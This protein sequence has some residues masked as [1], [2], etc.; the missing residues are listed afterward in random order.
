MQNSSVRT[1]NIVA[2]LLGV[3]LLGGL[4]LTSLYN[5]LLFHSLVE[6]FTIVVA[7]GIFMIAWNARAYLNNNYLLFLGIAAVFIAFL[8]IFHTLAYKG[9]GVF[10]DPS[11]NTATQV[12][13]GMQY[14][15]G[16]SLLVAPIFIGR[17]LRV[18]LQ[19]AAYLLVTAL[20]L[21]AI[22]AWRIFPVAYVQVLGLTPFKIASEYITVAFFL[23]SIAILLWKRREFDASVLRFLIL[24]L[25]F[26]IASE[27]AFT[28]YVSVY[29]GAN[30]VGHL[31]R[32]VAFFFLYKAI[33]ETGVV[34]PYAILLRDLQHSEESLRQHA[35][36]LQTRSEELD[37]YDH[38][39]AHNLKNPLTVI[40]ASAEAITDIGD[41]TPAEQREFMEQIKATAFEMNSI[42]DNLLL[43]AELRKAEAPAEP[44]NMAT[45]VA[46]IHKR[47]GYII[48]TNQARLILPKTWPEVSGYGPW[49]E[50]VWANYISNAIKYGG[51]KPCVELGATLQQDGMVRLWVRDQGPG[52][53]P[54]AQ[55]R[56]FVPFTQVGHV[57]QAGHGLGLSIVRSIVEKL[58]GQVGVESQVGQGSLFYFTLPAASNGN[59]PPGPQPQP[60][61]LLNL[62]EQGD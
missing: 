49:I 35:A 55:L 20:I 39:V 15:Q 32:L 43:L 19:L 8:D 62:S 47:L 24:F 29:G 2:S 53:P 23:A 4:Y 33:I 10:A 42:I 13:V 51:P 54:E 34:R 40:I 12:W 27:L 16:L 37:A 59:T 1:K 52:I 7:A 26:T 61:G 58:G 60:R 36:E 9:M 6:L 18:G 57:H 14:L 46:K 38:T 56:L 25:A 48:K 3:L 11:A 50:E 28:S 31:L 41:L 30:L 44:V 21:G 5:Y 45:L 17:K 22:F